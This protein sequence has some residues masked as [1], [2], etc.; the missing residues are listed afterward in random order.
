VL[1]VRW[2]DRLGRNYRDVTDN[3]RTFLRRGIVIK[4]V[5][6]GLIF[7]GAAKTPMEQAVRDA[8]VAF[9]SAMAEAQVEAAKEAQRAGIEHA[10]AKNRVRVYKG[11]KPSFTRSELELITDML[12][13]GSGASEISKLTGLT[14]QTVLRIRSDR[15]GAAAALAAWGL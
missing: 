10:K 3:V 8:L 7:D 14:R 4:T 1:V 6:N 12:A 11:R 13:N 9:M 15:V 2:I 5:I